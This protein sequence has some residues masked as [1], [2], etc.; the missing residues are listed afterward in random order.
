VRT[1]VA[2]VRRVVA[3][4]L[5]LYRSLFRWVTRRPDVPSHAVAFAYI[6]AVAALLWAF[7]V[8][9]AVELVV[10]HLLL[11]WEVVRIAAD[12]ISVWGLAWMLGLTASFTVYPHLVSDSGLRIRHGAGTDI[13]VPWDAIATIGVRERS[14][15]KSRAVQLDRDEQDTVLSVV[16]ASRTNVDLTF[17]RPLVVPLNKGDESVTELRL[18]ADDARGLVRR[19]REHVAPG[20]AG[21][22]SSRRWR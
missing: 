10:L 12:V 3:F 5:A 18:Y 8:V 15:D 1:A 17:R 19:V 13:T 6:G 2:L 11:P 22:K 14:R 21:L 9:S 20:A 7:I 16:I 4:E